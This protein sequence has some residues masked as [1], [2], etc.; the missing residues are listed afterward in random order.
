M[1][2]Q[3]E[4]LN[5]LENRFTDYLLDFLHN[6]VSGGQMTYGFEYEFISREALNLNQ[7]KKIYLFLPE[8]GFI[9]HNT[10]FVHES[11]YSPVCTNATSSLQMARRPPAKGCLRPF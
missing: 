10:S 5:E 7:M 8:I 6:K 9:S 1:T 3:T 11:E 4:D 2:T